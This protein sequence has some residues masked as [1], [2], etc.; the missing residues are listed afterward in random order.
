VGEM[1]LKKKKN[2]KEGEENTNSLVAGWAGWADLVG[3]SEGIKM[4]RKL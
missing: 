4:R 3:V 1:H 2:K